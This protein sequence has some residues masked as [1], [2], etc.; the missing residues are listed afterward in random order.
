MY[1]EHSGVVL[2]YQTL[3]H[4]NTLPAS[5]S[6]LDLNVPLIGLLMDSGELRN[7]HALLLLLCGA[8]MCQQRYTQFL[9]QR[10]ALDVP[11][12]HYSGSRRG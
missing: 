7:P 9:P 6:T 4:L 8:C 2:A 5:V 3:P 1:L 10:C 12:V 11:D